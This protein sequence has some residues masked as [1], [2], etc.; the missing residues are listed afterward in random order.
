[1]EKTNQDITGEQCMRNDDD[2]VLAVSDDN[3][4]I[5]WKLLN[6]EFIWDHNSLDKDILKLLISKMKNGK[7][8]APS[9]LVAETRKSACEAGINMIA[10]LINQ[11][12]VER[13]IP[14]LWELS[15][16]VNCYKEQG[17]MYYWTHGND[18]SIMQKIQKIWRVV[19]KIFLKK[20]ILG[21]KFDLLTPAGPGQEF[22]FEMSY[23]CLISYKKSKNSSTRFRV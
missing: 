6:K 15:D 11:I 5:V 8:K 2:G 18:C 3:K 9:G 1:M 7:A 4:R 22:S 13:V 14:V 10:D 23:Y 12:I 21:P 16:I 19:Q 20:S 17:T